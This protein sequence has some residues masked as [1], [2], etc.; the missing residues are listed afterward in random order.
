MYKRKDLRVL[1]IIQKAR[2][3][4]DGDLLNEAL[5]KQLIDADFCEISEKEKE[6]LATLLNSLI[7]AK[8]K[9]LLSN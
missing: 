5:V 2:E 6:E 9:A 4:G 7:N 1:K 8:D 3:I